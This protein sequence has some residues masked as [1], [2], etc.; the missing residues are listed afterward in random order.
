[1][2]DWEGNQEIS[3]RIQNSIDQMG[4]RNNRT[5]L[6]RM[7]DKGLIGE[8]HWKAFEDVRHKVT[9]GKPFDGNHETLI[10]NCDTLYELFLILVARWIGYEGKLTSFSNNGRPLRTLKELSSL[11]T[12]VDPGDPPTS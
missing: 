6:K 12:P 9:H 2:S 5:A 3:K 10:T 1:M 7:A 4:G 8:R 11:D